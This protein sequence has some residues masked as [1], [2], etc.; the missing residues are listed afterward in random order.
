[1][2]YKDKPPVG[3]K[4]GLDRV[5]KIIAAPRSHMEASILLNDEYS[6]VGLPYQLQTMK[7][8]KLDT[9]TTS[10]VALEL[11]LT[12][13]L[14][15]PVVNWAPEEYKSKFDTDDEYLESIGWR[16]PKRSKKLK[17][18]DLGTI[19]RI[20]Y[21]RYFGP[22][23]STISIDDYDIDTYIDQG[24]SYD[25]NNYYDDDN[26][27]TKT[28]D[29]GSLRSTTSV[30]TGSIYHDR[31]TNTLR[32]SLKPNI[33]ATFPTTS[34]SIEHT[35]TITITIVINRSHYYSLGL[36]ITKRYP[37][38]STKQKTDPQK[39]SKVIR[40]GKSEPVVI[41]SYWSQIKKKLSDKLYS[42]PDA[43]ITNMCDDYI[44]NDKKKVQVKLWP[45]KPKQHYKLR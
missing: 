5:F 8:Y 17:G 14:K 31:Q 6:W 10:R 23:A 45:S 40:L 28:Y 32:G 12:S 9:E 42:N 43:T 39:Q 22:S 27:E 16:K 34:D 38:V 26:F 13:P 44:Q 1:M 15:V 11:K 18:V 37:I 21:D 29:G 30:R 3:E 41:N 24:S 2:E 25:D 33:G 4:V 7:V 19:N 36:P 20:N 35:G